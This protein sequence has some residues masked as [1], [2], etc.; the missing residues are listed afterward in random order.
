MPKSIGFF[1]FS[2]YENNVF[3]LQFYCLNQGFFLVFVVNNTL[4]VSTHPLLQ[5][6][7]SQPHLCVRV[8]Q[9]VLQALIFKLKRVEFLLLSAQKKIIVWACHIDGVHILFG[10]SIRI[11]EFPCLNHFKL[12]LIGLHYHV[13]LFIC[14]VFPLH[15]LQIHIIS[16]LLV[17]EFVIKQRSIVECLHLDLLVVSALVAEW[18]VRLDSHFN[19]RQFLLLLVRKYY[20]HILLLFKKY[21]FYRRVGL[22]GQCLRNRGGGR[23]GL[24]LQ[25]G[26]NHLLERF[27]ALLVSRFFGCMF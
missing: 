26:G 12:E 11:F 2:F 24:F 15:L 27:Y 8:R 19:L 9:E 25:L 14:L 3:I 10:F 13:W 16:K 4:F 21:W 6:P 23:Q 20:L 7:F 22:R 18:V 17:S 5:L 1:V